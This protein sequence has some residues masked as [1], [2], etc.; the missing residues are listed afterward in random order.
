MRN[1]RWVALIGVSVVLIG[2]GGITR[3]ERDMGWAAG[4]GDVE[5]VARLLEAGVDPNALSD[6]GE[7][8]IG[9]AAGRG[10]IDVMEMLLAAGADPTALSRT[11]NPPLLRVANGSGSVEAARWLVDHGVDPCQ[12]FTEPARG[13]STTPLELARIRGHTDLVVFLAEATSHCE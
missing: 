10:H 6:V 3:E 7:T 13:G 1:L 12:R 11:G 8:F 4:N 2:C 9:H 5:E